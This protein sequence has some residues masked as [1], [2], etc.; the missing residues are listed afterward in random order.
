MDKVAQ[1]SPKL[2]GRKL[3]KAQVL[4][5]SDFYTIRQTAAKF[6]VGY[7]SVYR[8]VH[9]RSIP[10]FRF[11]KQHRIPRKFVDGVTDEVLKSFQNGEA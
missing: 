2:K 8:A 5:E 4:P 6:N 10:S 1:E 3:L 9:A 7:F 11:G